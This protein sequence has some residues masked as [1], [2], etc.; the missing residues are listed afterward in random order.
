MASLQ[1]TIC[2]MSTMP[3]DQP[4]VCDLARAHPTKVVPCFGYHPWFTYRISIH[5][6]TSKDDHYRSL[7][8]P[9]SSQDQ[10]QDP[11]HISAYQRLLPLLP[12]PIGLDYILSELRRNLEA[13]P[14]AMLGEVGLDR[15]FR[16]PFDYYAE[17]R[18]LTP[19]TVPFDHQLAILEAQLELAV[20]LGRN[21]SIHSVKSQLATAELLA[22]M[23]IKHQ[24]NWSRISLDL[25]SCGLSPESWRDIERKYKNVFLSLSTVINSRSPNHRA[26]IATCSPTRLLVESDFHN[27]DKCTERTWDMVKTVAEVR[28]WP[29][30]SEWIDDLDEDDWGTVR[31]LEENWFRFKKGYHATSSGTVATRQSK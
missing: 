31:K 24:E 6:S 16:V 5:P 2:A 22:K 3:E 25:H 27:V 17:R 18:E 13:F 11:A 28:G 7:F 23:Q 9:T 21:V 4:L 19:F 12:D 15:A 14:E 10:C 29:L 1:I 30:E 20:E 26:L 8:L